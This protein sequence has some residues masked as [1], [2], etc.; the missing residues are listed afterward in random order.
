ME[1]SVA[2]CT[3]NGEK[4]L[5]KQIES[6][7]NQSFDCNLEIIVC[8]DNSSDKTITILNDYKVKYPTTFEIIN[9]NTTIGS[10]KNFEKAIKKC[11]GEFIFLSD[12]DDIWEENKIEE[13][14]SIFKRNI[15]I[16][17]VFS[18]ANLINNEDLKYIE[19][20]LWDSV[21]FL[22]NR[23]PH[24]INF[25]DLIS[26]N[27]N[28]VTGATLCIKKEIKEFIFP[29]PEKILHDE[30]IAILLAVRETL[31]YSKKKLISYRIHDKQQVGINGIDKI[32][33]IQ[34]KKNIVLG[35]ES[36][37]YFKDYRLKLKKSF[38]KKDLL[39]SLQ[40]KKTILPRL[41]NLILEN[42]LEIET[43]KIEMNKKYP[44]SS[45][46]ASFIDELR[47]KRNS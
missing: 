27:G 5:E 46:I 24:P 25:V 47:G 8:D 19:M 4:Y 38:L 7:L 12:Q 33:K 17:G 34:R 2:L 31:D 22:E 45:Y 40:S 30:W 29:F 18:N 41:D 44:I 28:V 21:F 15:N 1:I 14:I 9:N 37:N 20:S 23:L 36:P 32:E 10:T 43:L 42:Q 16:E 39:N 11:Q 13:T 3:F 6:I 35:I 26:K